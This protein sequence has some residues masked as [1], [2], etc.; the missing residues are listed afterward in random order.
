M[1]YYLQ[2]IKEKDGQIN[3]LHD[4]IKQISRKE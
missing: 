4:I 3:G 1:R 2:R